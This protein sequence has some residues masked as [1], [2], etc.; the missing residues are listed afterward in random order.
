LLTLSAHLTWAGDDDP[1]HRPGADPVRLLAEGNQAYTE[2]DLERALQLYLQARQLGVNDAVLHFNLGNT[3][4][5]R[6]ELGQAV[7]SYLRARRL[8]PRDGD[9][10]ANLAWVRQHIKDL[11]L[12]DQRLPL[13]IAQAADV[14]GALTLDQWGVVLLLLVWVTGGLIAWGWYREGFGN[15]LRRSL[16]L[17]AA[18]LLVVATV[19]IGRWYYEE[20]RNQAVV[21]VEMA[22]VKSGPAEN[23]PVLFQVHDGLTVNIEGE[24]EGWVRI[25]LGGEWVGWLPAHSVTPVRLEPASF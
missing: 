9:I 23:F 11:E 12:T 15:R 24:R 2:G 18:G 1:R 7:A 17:S 21:T 4:A 16:L 25:G 3:Y 13:F 20:V 14:I 8:A 19:T 10:K 22:E 6:G 5:R